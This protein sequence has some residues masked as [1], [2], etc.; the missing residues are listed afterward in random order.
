M[1]RKSFESYGRIAENF[2]NY[3]EISGRLKVQEESEKNIVA[4]VIKKLNLKSN[5]SLL[6]I[7]CGAGN[8]LIP[9][10]FAVDTIDGID[11]ISC[12]ELLKRRFPKGENINF[13][14]GNFLD[15]AIDDVYSKILC[16]SVLHYLKNRD[17]VFEFINKSL[18]LLS[19]GGKALFGDIPNSSLKN[20]FINSNRGRK[21]LKEWQALVNSETSGNQGCFD[22][23]DELVEFDD[24]FVAEIV[25]KYQKEGYSTYVLSQPENLPFGNTREDILIIKTD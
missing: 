6:E 14:P 17:E 12:I 20:R 7:G 18:R 11:H 10:S 4:D 5:D 9:L 3:T 19:P 13:I 21:F 23:D 16:Y 2:S 1:S 22:K 25:R 8:L 24:D 15:V